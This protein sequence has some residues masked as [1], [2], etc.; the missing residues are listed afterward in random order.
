MEAAGMTE[1]GDSKQRALALDLT[2]SFIVQAP[3]GSGKTELLTQ[4]FL[5]LLA[6]VD[7]PER[8][9][10]ITFTRKATREMRDRIMRR[11]V[12]AAT[13]AVNGAANGAANEAARATSGG[14]AGGGAASGGTTG[15]DHERVA[16]DL[17][18]AVLQRDAEMGW[19][20]L[21]NPGRLRVFTIDGLCTQLLARDPEQGSHLAGRA[22][23][24]DP[25]P[26]YRQA[27]QRMFEDLGH[28]E[29]GQQDAAPS[30]PPSKPHGQPKGQPPGQPEDQGAAGARAALVRVLVH[31]EGNSQ[32][33]QDLLVSMMQIRDQWTRRIGTDEFHMAELLRDR[34]HQELSQYKEAL[35]ER[36]LLQAM[37]IVA[38]LGKAMDDRSSIPALFALASAEAHCDRDPGG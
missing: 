8:I 26:L 22:L 37:A 36:A 10:A 28:K 5:K 33:L 38:E 7:R 6:G 3:A 16:V 4:R 15:L 20:L 19:N 1:P 13:G 29:P 9:L 18:K 23:P 25:K 12:Q 17:A 2:R 35:G 31:L 14:T 21:K 11:L 27:V 24:E 30:K 32:A 34:Q